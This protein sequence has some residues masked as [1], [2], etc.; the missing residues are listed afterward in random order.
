MRISGLKT[1]LSADSTQLYFTARATSTVPAGSTAAVTIKY[2][3][4]PEK[5]EETDLPDSEFEPRIVS[6][7]KPL[8]GVTIDRN[9][10]EG[11][12]NVK[13]ITETLIEDYIFSA[14]FSTV[15]IKL[16]VESLIDKPDNPDVKLPES[17]DESTKTKVHRIWGN[18]RENYDPRQFWVSSAY[19]DLTNA[20]TV[21]VTIADECILPGVFVPEQISE[22]DF[23]TLIASSKADLV[24][25]NGKVYMIQ[26]A[27]GLKKIGIL[28]SNSERTY[29]Q[30]LS[31]D[32]VYQFGLP[33][34]M[35]STRPIQSQDLVKVKDRVYTFDVDVIEMDSRHF[36]NEIYTI[37]S[38]LNTLDVAFDR[39]TLETLSKNDS[40]NFNVINSG[41]TNTSFR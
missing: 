6:S 32:Q 4:T 11:Y 8:Q 10:L 40:P 2:E 41:T 36:F 23:N 16:D 39:R 14:S 24:E 37:L 33:T 25:K 7:V 5:P 30:Y 21:E 17:D 35:T 26:T 34:Y 38:E 19:L 22:E 18:Y 13:D 3:Y 31:T 1:R 28:Y 12:I 29:A 15:Q 20:V 27:T 9:N